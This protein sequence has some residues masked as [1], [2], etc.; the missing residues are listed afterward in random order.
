MSSNRTIEYAIYVDKAK[1][2]AQWRYSYWMVRLDMPVSR[3][4]K[5]ASVGGMASSLMLLAACAAVPDLGAKPE[6]RAPA[7]VAA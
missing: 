3:I 5:V 6:L 4:A 7:S 1:R 2:E